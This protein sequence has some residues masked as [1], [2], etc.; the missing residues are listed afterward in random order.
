MQP[1]LFYRISKKSTTEGTVGFL[2]TASIFFQEVPH[3]EVAPDALICDLYWSEMFWTSQPSDRKNTWN[4][5]FESNY[6]LSR[7]ESNVP[8]V[9]FQ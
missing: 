9:I 3:H 7:F 2:D 4:M 1:I 6:S 8:L 5:V